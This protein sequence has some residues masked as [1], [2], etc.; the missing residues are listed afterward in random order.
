MI[1]YLFNFKIFLLLIFL[2]HCQINE[3]N[4]DFDIDIDIEG[5]LRFD[6]LYNNYSLSFQEENLIF[7]ESKD[8]NYH[9]FYYFNIIKF[10]FY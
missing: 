3:T 5:M 1:N 2:I 9:F 10:I 4:I 7:T 6:S 8:G